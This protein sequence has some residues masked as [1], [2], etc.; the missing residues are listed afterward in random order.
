MKL[1]RV[2]LTLL[3]ALLLIPASANSKPAEEGS[4]AVDGP[5]LWHGIPVP[6]AEQAQEIF[7]R[8]GFQVDGTGYIS[9]PLQIN[10]EALFSAELFVSPAGAGYHGEMRIDVAI[11]GSDQP[12][13]GLMLAYRIKNVSA[14]S[15]HVKR[16]RFSPTFTTDTLKRGWHN[17]PQSQVIA[18][19]AVASDTTDPETLWPI[20]STESMWGSMSIA[21]SG[22]TNHHKEWQVS[23]T[24]R[25]LAADLLCYWA[26]I[27]TGT[28]QPPPGLYKP[29]TAETIPSSATSVSGNSARVSP[30]T[31]SSGAVIFNLR[32]RGDSNFIVYLDNA[33]GSHVELLANEAGNWSGQHLVHI[34]T[35]GTYFVNVE[36]GNG[37]WT[38]DW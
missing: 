9:P 34:D 3:C 17:G 37:S 19:F 20:L 4:T 5:N 21:F 29:D 24:D 27:E 32:Y 12:I 33:D 25:Q 11:P 26:A 6:N 23:Q 38:V 30:V 8:D 28:I 22:G 36:H 18:H 1:V 16:W 13:T 14:V 7:D 10:G 35:G 15:Y 2:T 31:L